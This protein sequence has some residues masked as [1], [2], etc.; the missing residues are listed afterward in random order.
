VIQCRRLRWRKQPG[1]TQT[2]S[3]SESGAF[4][5]LVVSPRSPNISL[6]AGISS[7]RWRGHRPHADRGL[8]RAWPT[9]P[10]AYCFPG[11]GCPGQSGLG[12]NARE[13]ERGRRPRRCSE[14]L[15]HG[16]VGRHAVESGHSSALSGFSGPWPPQEGSLGG[17]HAASSDDPERDGSDENGLA[18]RM[19]NRCFPVRPVYLLSR[20]D[21][22]VAGPRSAA[23]G[24]GGAE[25]PGATRSA[26]LARAWRGWRA[27][28]LP[29]SE[30]RGTLD[31]SRGRT[32]GPK[33]SDPVMS[34]STHDL[35]K[36]A[37]GRVRFWEED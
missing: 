21:L 32:T 17:M 19:T 7:R 8:A 23:V 1:S 24:M 13:T 26:L 2:A 28:D 3:P 16:D 22:I 11:R 9:R 33:G 35:S 5:E 34:A 37:K 36:A 12:T 20:P 18:R 6:E 30:H 10:A 29:R 25:P 27:P 31:I 14:R 4:R 15:V